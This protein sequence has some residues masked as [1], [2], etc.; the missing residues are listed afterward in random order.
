[1]ARVNDI[2][3]QPFIFGAVER[4]YPKAF[5]KK[6]EKYIL[7]RSAMA[8]GGYNSLIIGNAMKLD[9]ILD[10][11]VKLSKNDISQFLLTNV[12]DQSFFN[13]MLARIDD[14]YLECYERGGEERNEESVIK[15]VTKGGL[16]N[17]I[18]GTYTTS[19]S[20]FPI[21]CLEILEG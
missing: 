19:M 1:M 14:L 13:H 8:E 2:L 6:L 15:D 9:N 16:A 5:Q 4:S 17:Q 7:L 12:I 10:N 18:Q 11:Y 20:S 3:Y 21:N